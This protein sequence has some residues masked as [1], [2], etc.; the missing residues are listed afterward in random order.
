MPSFRNI[1][2]LIFDFGGVLMDLDKERCIQNF[3]DLGFPDVER[4]LGEFLQAGIFLDMEKGILDAPAFRSEIRKKVSCELSDEQIDEAWNSFLV[5]MPTEKL[6]MLLELKKKFK[7]LL[8]SNT[9]PIHMAYSQEIF[10]QHGGK[11]MSG[12]FH[13]RYLSYEMGLAKPDAAIFQK[14]VEDADLIPSEC[15]FLD[16][17]IKN[18]EEGS[19]IGFQTYLVS[20]NKNLGFLLEEE[21][22]Q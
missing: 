18:I 1:T 4:Y 21:T 7:L 2:T 16:D 22:W 8:L 14:M 20:K 9:N 15:L 13:K 17:G 11:P 3:K 12:Y 6:D 10:M 19:R 5:G